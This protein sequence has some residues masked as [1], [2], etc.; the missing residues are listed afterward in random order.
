MATA[1]ERFDEIWEGLTVKQK[2]YV[3]ARQ[4]VSSKI[5]AA[6]KIGVHSNTVYSYPDEVEEAVGLVAEMAVDSAL[7]VLG[8]AVLEAAIGKAGEMEGQGA[9]ASKARTEILDRVLG[10][11]TQR[12]EVSQ[13]T[14]HSFDE[15]ALKD[16]DSAMKSVLSALKASKEEGEE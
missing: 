6:R 12:Q 15:S 11:A 13:E 7:R 10:K 2:K 9:E 14:K 16:A 3:A 8:D 1:K 5:D 4:A